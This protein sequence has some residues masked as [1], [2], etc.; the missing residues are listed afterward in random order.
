MGVNPHILIIDGLCMVPELLVTSP[1]LFF[2]QLKVYLVH[3]AV[4]HMLQRYNLSVPLNRLVHLTKDLRSLLFLKTF[5]FLKLQTKE[6]VCLLSFNS[7]FLF[8]KRSWLLVCDCWTEKFGFVLA[9]KLVPHIQIFDIFFACFVDTDLDVPLYYLFLYHVFFK[10]VLAHKLL[11]THL[12][13]IIF[14]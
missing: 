11:V 4:F 3:L 5:L 8:Y 14:S 9:C 13:Y 6:L 1:R 10:L 2:L 12:L 7:R